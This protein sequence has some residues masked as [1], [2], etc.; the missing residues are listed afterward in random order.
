VW[1]PT[2]EELSL[3]SDAEVVDLMAA[4]DEVRRAEEAIWTAQ[5]KQ[6]VATE[7]ASQADETLYGGAAG[8]GKTEWLLEYA[9]QQMEQHA[10][11]RGAIFRR[12]YPSLARTIVPRSKAKYP[13]CGARWNG[14]E[15]TWTF[16]N[17]SVLELGALQYEDSVIDHQ[18]AEY[19]FLAFEEVTEFLESQ[20][21]YMI[22]RL[23]APAP[24]IRPHLVATSN[25]GGR[26]H[27]WVKRRWV[28][29][30]PGDWEADET[31]PPPPGTIW[32]PRRTAERPNPG[33]RAFVPATL[34]DNPLLMKRDPGY[35]D[36]LRAISN[37]AL[38]LAMEKGDW[39]AI[40]AVEG[41]LWEQP[42]LDLGRV[43]ARHVANLGV[44]E[45]CVALDPS[46]GL[47][48]GDEFGVWAGARGLDGV[49]YTEYSAGWRLSPR[50][51]AEKAVA[52]YHQIQ[53]DAI[54]VE[55]NHG[56][57]WLKEVL[58]GVDRYA[59]VIEVWAS[60]KKIVRAR[61]VAA[62]FE[63][64]PTREPVQRAALAGDFPELEE[65]LTTFTGAADEA[66]PNR[67]DA[68]AWGHWHLV[69][70]GRY[71]RE[72]QYE[73]DRLSGRR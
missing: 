67:L 72:S 53:A 47:A 23:R 60:D 30:K 7:I 33:R 2:D 37:R 62:L 39:D 66:S 58:L 1:L 13:A 44:V 34:A 5:P 27:R 65:E 10:W 8:G 9:R 16:P 20:V 57:L 21:E 11:N 48:T 73:D 42:W 17:G 12:V 45:R 61:P 31:A 36:R 56:G 70:G 41:A 15:H 32:Q 55:K 59:N 40:D 68:L 50:K 3:M 52:L 22:G 38:R 51:M 4:L 18:G 49:C 26:G 14:V 6:A 19:G 24:G 64:D 35:I 54:V 46:D 29:P 71:A 69:L 43:T 28:K 25:P 63:P